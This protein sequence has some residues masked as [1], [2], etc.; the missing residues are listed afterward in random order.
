MRSGH[1]VSGEP[2]ASALEGSTR[3]RKS[4]PIARSLGLDAGGLVSQVRI[5]G[6]PQNMGTRA[7]ERFAACTD[8]RASVPAARSRSSGRTG[9]LGLRTLATR[10]VSFPED[11]GS[12]P[13]MGR[14]LPQIRTTCQPSPAP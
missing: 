12:S 4:V 11:I 1:F 2:Q 6:E 10:V 14:G 7:T 13:L 8:H 9:R 5:A 3:G